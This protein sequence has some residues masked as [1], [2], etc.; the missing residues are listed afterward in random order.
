MSMGKI[1]GIVILIIFA[2]WMLDVNVTEMF[3]SLLT[4]MKEMKNKS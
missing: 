3:N 4:F 2:L 1:V